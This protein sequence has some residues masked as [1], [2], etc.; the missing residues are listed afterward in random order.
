LK[1]L[2]NGLFPQGK[3]HPDIRK[4][5]E[6]EAEEKGLESLL[7]KL[8]KIDPEYAKK[9][10]TNDKFRTVRALEV[11]EATKRP[12]SEHFTLTRSF[13]E[14]FHVI[15]IG[16]KIERQILYKNI[17]KRV[18]KMFSGGLVN[19]VKSILEKGVNEESPPFRALG[20]KHVL[21]HL[22]NELPLAEAISLTKRDTRHYAKRQMTWFRKMEGITW[23]NPEEF[24]SLKE[25]IKKSL[26]S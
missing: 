5:L 20:Y 10:G 4:R 25:Y 9:I 15:K 1:A 12:L 22:K 13:V 11:F 6:T 2:L 24:D 18:D 7:E 26:V 23:F 3:S 19:E 21:K 17:E 8:R 16:L 14:D